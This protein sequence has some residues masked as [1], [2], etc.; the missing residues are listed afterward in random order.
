M[1]EEREFYVYIAGVEQWRDGRAN[2]KKGNNTILYDTALSGNTF[3]ITTGNEG[4]EML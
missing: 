2:L 3:L 4:G 1:S